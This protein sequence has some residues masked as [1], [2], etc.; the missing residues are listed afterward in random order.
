MELQGIEFLIDL[1]IILRV[2]IVFFFL[3]GALYY[4]L[5]GKNKRI[6]SLPDWFCFLVILTI[7]LI[8]LYGEY[9][10]NG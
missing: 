7:L 6:E 8:S 2:I 5:T 3:I 9:F 10:Y 4:F 1:K